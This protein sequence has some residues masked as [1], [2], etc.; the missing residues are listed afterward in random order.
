MTT[1]S[2]YTLVAADLGAGVIGFRSGTGGSLTPG[3]FSGAAVL[4]I[5]HDPAGLDALVV[6]I[7]G[8]LAKDVFQSITITDSLLGD[9]TFNTANATFELNSGNAQWSWPT[10]P[11]FALA[12][13]Y[14]V[15]IDTGIRYNCECDEDTGYET[16]GQLRARLMVRLGYAGQVNN[17]PPGMADLL[18]DFLAS[19]QRLLYQKYTELHT[20]RFFTWT[21]EPNIRFYDIA[22]NDETCSKR[23]NALKITWVGVED[24]NYAWYPMFAGISPEVYTFTPPNISIPQRY[25]IRQCIE[26]WP[27]PDK[28]Y[29]LRIKGHYTLQPFTDDANQTTIDSELV[30]LWA[31]ATAKAH[32]GHPD[33]NNI[34]AMANDYLG[35]LIGGKHLTKRYIPRS[36]PVAPAIRPLMRD[37]YDA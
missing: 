25:E 19:S 20:E 14:G 35:R 29:R 11:L 21:M 15:A 23:L 32:Y 34:A 28:A 16:R 7:T 27:P 36:Y 13:S 4:A 6:R 24:L 30:F 33:A 3:T 8:A 12:G 9:V 5:Q 17:P 22:E 31:L 10:A 18:N 37:G 1:I 2:S 26:V